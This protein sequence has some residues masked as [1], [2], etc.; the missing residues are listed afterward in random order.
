ML[1]TCKK[2]I[3]CWLKLNAGWL[4]TDRR[5]WT[6]LA[7]RNL[8]AKPFFRNGFY[9]PNFFLKRLN[10]VTGL[11]HKSELPES[12]KNCQK[13]IPKCTYI[14]N[15]GSVADIDTQKI[16]QQ[17]VVRA[18]LLEY[19]QI[20]ECPRYVQMNQLHRALS[21]HNWTPCKEFFSSII[22]CFF[23]CR[24]VIFKHALLWILTVNFNWQKLT[25]K[26]EKCP[27]HKSRS[28]F[29]FRFTGGDR[30]SVLVPSHGPGAMWGTAAGK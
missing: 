20:G 9:K 27:K 26:I 1:W 7:F 13:K 28:A 5:N 3:H 6:T 2:P 24:F 12:A 8:W 17:I 29:T 14:A 30:A 19:A 15:V 16:Q 21:V 4:F 25:V 10:N 18:S 11:E 22:D 23:S